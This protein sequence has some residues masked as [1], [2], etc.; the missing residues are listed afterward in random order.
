M[1]IRDIFALFL[2]HMKMSRSLSMAT[3][4][5]E[6]SLEVKNLKLKIFNLIIF[7]PHNILQ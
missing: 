4:F 1:N 5:K 7:D 2:W 3:K 6:N